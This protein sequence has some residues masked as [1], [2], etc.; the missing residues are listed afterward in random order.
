MSPNPRAIE[1]ATSHVIPTG[2]FARL[3]RWSGRHR[4]WVIAFWIVLFLV[5][6][7]LAGKLTGRLSQ[8]GFEIS[9]STSQG[10]NNVL[11]KKFTNE[12]P[13]N[14]TV[15]F[16]SS[17][18]APSDPAFQAVVA[19]TAAAV[20]QAGGKVVGQV[21]TP[22]QNPQLAYP[23]AHT[24]LAQIGLTESLDQVLAHTKSIIDA[25]NAQSTSDVK[26]GVTSG[27]AIYTD[28]NAV[29]AHDLAISEAV[30]VPLILLVLVIFFGSLWAAG[31]PVVVTVIGLVTTLG[32]LWFVAGWTSL[33]IYV[34]NVV[35]LIGIGIGVDYS[36]FIVNRFRDE[37]REGFDPLDAAAITTGRA[38]KAIFFSGLTVAVALAGMFAVGV[39]IFTGFAVGT[40][41]VVVVLV[42]ASL[43]FTPAV[44]VALHTRVFR[45]DAVA[46]VRR[47]FHRPPRQVI[48]DD[49]DFG[50]WGRW[51]AAVMRRPWTVV[52]GVTAVLLVLASPVLVMKTG[53]SGVTAL[54]KDVPSRVA[55]G[56]LV[57]AAGPGAEDPISVVFDGTTATAA[58]T[59]AAANDFK[60]SMVNDPQVSGVGPNLAVS[61]DGS[62]VV[63][64]VYPKSSEDSQAAQ[65]LAGRIADTYGPQAVANSAVRVYVGGAASA[66][67]DF[68]A[69]VAG[70]LP[71]VI[72]LVM[73]L[74]FIVLTVLFRSL[75]LPLKAVVM[76]LLS[77]LAA[78]GVMV[79]V[80]Q[81]GWADSI[82]RFDHLGH[83]TNWVPAFMFSILF[84]LSMDYEVF[85]LSRVREYRDRGGSDNDAVAFGLART[86][87]I[88]STAAL[89]M[90]I[91]FLSFGSNRL[92]PLKEMS[93]GLAVAILIDATLVRLLLV[94]AFMRL[95]GK[96]NWWLPAWMAKAIPV[97]E[98]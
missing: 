27:P 13:A 71:Y 54:P 94:P 62:A 26:V 29:N 46:W 61:T 91:V 24:A 84:G 40:I 80:F 50:F 44:L 3:G 42:A 36:L 75:V 92:I 34:Q 65:D 52:I 85:L 17:T 57:A 41:G 97:I 5:M 37:L 31:I 59:R 48:T 19:K 77:V 81:W 78:Y 20:T 16:S 23:N 68:T 35:P 83:V 18:L 49:G 67:R 72:G 90:I 10:A 30:Q 1:R 73:I 63:V 53:S 74:T 93:L 60:T 21:V 70:R 95:A 86:G 88:I 69:A 32:A 64:T 82:L 11:A 9:G 98:E 2:P 15:V 55:A 33:S 28:F 14:M 58:A 89:L 7:P 79:A 87:R 66:N 38:G 56:Q 12:F 47:L 39:P 51:A 25:A 4:R 76:T 96:W 22:V 43:T 8:G 6:A 45:W